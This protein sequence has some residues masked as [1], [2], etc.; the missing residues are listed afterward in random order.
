MALTREQKEAQVKEL[1]KKM[2]DASSVILA[3]YIGLSVA[4]INALRRQ[5][6]TA[7][8]EMKVAK[9]TLMSLATQQAGLPD[10]PMEMLEG[11]VSLIF[12]F[13]DPLS[14]A[15]I[16]FRYAKNHSQVELIGGVYD[17]KL[18]S[19][20]KVLEL[21]KMPNRD[22]L[23]AIFASMLRSPLFRFASL[24]GS[25]LT[26]FAHALKELAEK[27]GARAEVIPESQS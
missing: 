5:L 2:S 22:Q 21:A 11:P 12:S 20:A 13:G 16:A 24:C 8:A 10:I 3:H 1:T 14:G 7:E 18:L 19:K 15:Q 23:L 26:G 6:K 17:G 9:K 4:E 27:G 25:P